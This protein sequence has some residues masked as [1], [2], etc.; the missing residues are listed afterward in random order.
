MTE[1]SMTGATGSNAAR[2]NGIDDW[3]LY[4]GVRT[5]RSVAFLI[6][7]LLIALLT[8]PA[9]IVVAILGFITFGAAWL[10]FAVLGP[11][12]ALTY[13]WLTLGGTRQA[14]PGMRIMDVRLERLDGRRV[15]GMLAV[16]H[17]VLF[18]AANA[19]LTPMVLVATL[20]LDRKQTLHDLLLGT[21]VVR[22]D[23]LSRNR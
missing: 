22:D 16:V 10:F 3:R 7:Y 12:V 8:V 19:I 15:D 6:D 20:L 13:V 2:A 17:T 11:L 23:V 9:A 21:V 4:D 1:T 5:R 14:T 18:W